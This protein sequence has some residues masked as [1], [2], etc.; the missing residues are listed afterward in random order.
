MPSLIGLPVIKLT[1]QMTVANEEQMTSSQAKFAFHKIFTYSCLWERTV[2]KKKLDKEN[3][4]RMHNICT[5]LAPPPP[6]VTALFKEISLDYGRTGQNAIDCQFYQPVTTCQQVATDLSISSNCNKSVNK[7][8]FFQLVIC[9][10]LRQ[11]V[12][13]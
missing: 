4:K 5:T 10:L 1:V 7:S 11:L 13:S 3:L 2:S 12:A 9:N 8:G 6:T